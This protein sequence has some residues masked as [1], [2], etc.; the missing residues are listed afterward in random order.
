MSDQSLMLEILKTMQGDLSEVKETVAAH[1]HRF[2]HIDEQIEAITG[3]VT[4]AMGKSGEN[5]ADIEKIMSDMK[6][7]QARVAALETAG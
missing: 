1:T 5:R 4:Y 6:D 3:Y 2:D 7:L